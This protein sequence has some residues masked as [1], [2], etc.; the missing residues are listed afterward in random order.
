MRYAA[1]YAGEDRFW[2]G[3]TLL[4]VSALLFTVLG[5]IGAVI[6]VASVMLPLLLTLGYEPKVA[7]SLFLFIE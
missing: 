6:L 4:L 2:L 7:G 5:G 1:E 3:F